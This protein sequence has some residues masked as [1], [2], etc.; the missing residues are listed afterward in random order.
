LEKALEIAVGPQ[1]A[2][3]KDIKSLADRNEIEQIVARRTEPERYRELVGETSGKLAKGELSAQK[4]ENYIGKFIEER[5]KEL[6]RPIAPLAAQAV[7]KLI[8]RFPKVSCD[9]FEVLK[10][11]AYC[12][13]ELC[14]QL[15]NT[16]DRRVGVN[17][18]LTSNPLERIPIFS[19]K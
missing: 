9:N 12:E 6:G 14:F 19:A 4:G 8:D 11:M 1:P 16:L 7:F 15:M 3:G 13:A 5:L 17:S 18:I 2:A 10:E